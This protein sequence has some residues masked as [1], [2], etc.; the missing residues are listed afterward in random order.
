MA[1][2]SND[3]SK[4]GGVLARSALYAYASKHSKAAI[5][6]LAEVLHDP[7]IQPSVRMAAAKALLDK[8]LPDLK[9]TEVKGEEGG[10]IEIVIVKEKILQEHE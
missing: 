4:K 2:K 6:Y 3:Q 9:S 5:D 8:A 1:K 10:P 7:K